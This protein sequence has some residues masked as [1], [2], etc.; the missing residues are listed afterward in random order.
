LKAQGQSIMA[1]EDFLTNSSLDVSERATE[2]WD[3][4][5]D[6]TL[7]GG[8]Y[9]IMANVGAT[10]AVMSL[11][12]FIVN[13]AKQMMQSEAVDWVLGELVY[14]MMVILMLSN[15]GGNLALLS[16]GM[17][18]TINYYNNQILEAV[19]SQINFDVA[20]SQL[21]D[22][23]T[24]NA[25]LNS[26]RSQCNTI[27]DNQKLIE[28]LDE[29]AL[30]ARV[31]VEEYKR[32]HPQMPEWAQYLLDKTGISKIDPS[33]PLESVG[34]LAVSAATFNAS[35]LADFSS[36]ALLI[37]IEIVL[38][39]MQ[40]CFQ[41]LIEVSFLLTALIGPIAVGASLLP[42]GTKPIIAWVTGFFSLGMC[43]L[44]LNIITGLIAIA[45][46]RTGPTVDTLGVALMLGLL[47]P[48]LAFG[49]AAG[50]GMAVFNGVTSAIPFVGNAVTTVG[51]IGKR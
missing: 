22:F 12:F 42:F 10:I 27:S 21:A 51:R 45:T 26:M 28:C 38:A 44:C 32:K 39:T 36:N 13:F 46:L 5:W 48:L 49:M 43:K 25:Q 4:L 47:A 29:Q 35:L 9:R 37:G 8:L 18:T 2:S 16:Q 17:R 34:T 30:N 33:K 50:G 19:S 20:L 6:A 41:Q 23:S 1:M 24:A 14:P 40:G 3:F 11:M 7:S 15:G 31:L